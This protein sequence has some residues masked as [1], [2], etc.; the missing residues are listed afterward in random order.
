MS[1]TLWPEQQ[2]LYGHAY[3]IYCLATSNKGDCAASSCKAKG[4]QHSNIVIWDLSKAKG[5]SAGGVVPVCKLFAHSYT[6]I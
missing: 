2:K 3:E 4:K 6:V 5:S 1:K